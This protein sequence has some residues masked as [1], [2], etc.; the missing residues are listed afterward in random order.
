[1]GR[2]RGRR[3]NGR[4]FS[5]FADVRIEP[6]IDNFLARSIFRIA[7]NSAKLLFENAIISTSALRIVPSRHDACDSD[8]KDYC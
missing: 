3:G 2:Q 8:E 5:S 7:R 6:D 4:G 1:M